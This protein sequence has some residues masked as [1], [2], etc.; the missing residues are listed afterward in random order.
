MN[1]NWR[2]SSHSGGEGNCVEIGNDTRVLVRDTKQAGQGPMLRFTP[3]A[4]R[5]FAVQLKAD[6]R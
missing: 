3:E 1:Y 5:R 2:T 4:W 6:A